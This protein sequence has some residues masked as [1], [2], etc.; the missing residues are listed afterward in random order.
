MQELG[1]TPPKGKEVSN[2]KSSSCVQL[3][4]HCYFHQSDT[5]SLNARNLEPNTNSHTQRQS[6]L[7]GRVMA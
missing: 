7:V 6:G 5:L 2:S 3:Y 1:S 4:G